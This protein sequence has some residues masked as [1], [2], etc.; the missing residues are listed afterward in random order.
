MVVRL[1]ALR[2]GRFYP[3]EILLVLIS[4]RGWVYPRAIVRSEGLCQWKI[5]M[6]PAG[7]EPATFRFVAQHINHCATAAVWY[8]GTPITRPCNIIILKITTWLQP[9][10]VESSWPAVMSKRPHLAPRYRQ[11]PTPALQN[12]G[13]E[14]ETDAEMGTLHRNKGIP[15]LYMTG[16]TC[17]NNNKEKVN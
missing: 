16:F 4:I 12:E 14:F 17:E 6:T 2:T 3:Q 5:P 9:S 8:V 1:T 15:S 10:C 7:I 11:L 13:E